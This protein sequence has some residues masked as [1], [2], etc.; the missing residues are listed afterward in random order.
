MKTK[1][2]SLTLL[3]FSLFLFSCD[4]YDT[5]VV[6]NGKITTMQATFTD[7]KAIE[8]SSA[9]S[10]YL[11]FSD[12]EE[13][14]EIEANENLHQ[15]I[16][17]K[18]ENGTLKIG[19]ENNVQIRGNATLKAYI[20]TKQVEGY[21]AS[22]ASRFIVENEIHAENV[23]IYLSGASTF[24]GEINS[25]RC[26]ANLSGASSMNILGFADDFE[27][28]ASGA[29]V[30]RDYGFEAN[31]LKAELSGASNAYL[32]VDNEIEIEASGASSLRYKGDAVIT[33]QNLSGASSVK[34]M[35]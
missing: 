34:Q 6:P 8:A 31:H 19:I 3:S 22:G 7:Y 13:S 27:L 16:D 11:V 20:I 17:V 33:T 1:L 30:I 28:D 4:I 35:N 5:E 25:N 18:K 23:N 10:V 9:F 12:T 2:L 32:T 26:Y 14:I 21:S 15:Y 24:D 29:S